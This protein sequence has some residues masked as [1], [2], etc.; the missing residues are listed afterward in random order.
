MLW[1]LISELGLYYLLRYKFSFRKSYRYKPVAIL[2]RSTNTS[3]HYIWIFIFFENMMYLSG[4]FRWRSTHAIFVSR[5]IKICGWKIEYRPIG[6]HNFNF[7]FQ[8]HLLL[9]F[10]HRPRHFHPRSPHSPTM[11]LSSDLNSKNRTLLITWFDVFCYQKIE[12][13]IIYVDAKRSTFRDR[14]SSLFLGTAIMIFYQE[15]THGADSSPMILK[16]RTKVE[17]PTAIHALQRHALRIWIT[18]NIQKFIHYI[19]YLNVL[20]YIQNPF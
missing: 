12:E 17:S 8:V 7:T 19:F 2:W 6:F 1:G 13:K 11:I 20:K 14:A 15:G 3:W 10:F 9:R 16:F 4:I 18:E 5:L